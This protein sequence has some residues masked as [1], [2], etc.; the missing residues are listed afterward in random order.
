MSATHAIA[1]PV[2]GRTLAE[3]GAEV[4]QFNHYNDFEHQWVYDDANVGQR[5]AFLDLKAPE[6]ND[7]AKGLARK[8]D[9]FVDSY[10]GRKIARFGFSPEEL[11]SLS[12]K[13][14]Q[15]S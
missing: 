13:N 11:A 14:S 4:L 9:I 1:G 12:L 8:A 7:V 10:R 15:K 2:V 5:S 6:D 3:Q